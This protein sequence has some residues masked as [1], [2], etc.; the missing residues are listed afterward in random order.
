[1]A[2]DRTSHFLHGTSAHLDVGDKVLPANEIGRQNYNYASYRIGGEG[3]ERGDYVYAMDERR[4]VPGIA[5]EAAWD[6]AQTARAHH[7]G[8]AAVYRVTPENDYTDDK[9]VEAAVRTR[10]PA[11]VVDRIDIRPPHREWSDKYAT[12]PTKM[13]R[14]GTLPPVDWTAYVDERYESTPW[15]DWNHPTLDVVTQRD[16]TVRGEKSEERPQRAD[17]F[18]EG[19]GQLFDETPFD[20]RTPLQKYDDHRALLKSRGPVRRVGAW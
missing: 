10:G 14:Q 8:R 3:Q 15:T 11:E 2:G 5:E 1:M 18:V 20:R 17:S 4:K 6:W 9:V 16:R 7:G 19:Q 13:P 12:E